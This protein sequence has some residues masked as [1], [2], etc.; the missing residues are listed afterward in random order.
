MSVINYF[1]ENIILPLSDSITRQNVSKHLKFLLNSQWFDQNEL[2]KYQSEKLQHLL[3]HSYQNVPYYH[4]LFKDLGIEPSDIKSPGDLEKLPILTKRIIR[5]NV[6]KNT[7]IAGNIPSHQKKLCSSSG[8]TGEPLF[9]YTSKNAYGKR[10][11]ASLRGWYWMGYRLGDKYVKISQN[12]RSR[13][14]KRVQDD[15]SRNRYLPSNPLTYDNYRKILENIEKYQ[16]KVIRC[17]PDP[18]YFIAKYLDSSPAYDINPLAVTTTGNTLFPEMRDVIEKGFK[19]RIFDAYSCEGSTT[20]FEC[21]THECYHSAMEFG[22][23]EVLDDNGKVIKDGIGRL[24]STDLTNLVQPFIRYDTQDYVEVSSKPCSCGR[25]LLRINRI[26]GRANDVLENRD[27]RKFIVH[28]FTGFFQQDNPQLKRSINNFQI[29]KRKG[30]GLL[31][32]LVVNSFYDDSVCDYIKHFW[33]NE[34]RENINIEIVNEIPLLP[35]GK[36]KFIIV[37]E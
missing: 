34:Y 20:I 23:T 3:S 12:P 5:E 2:L 31:F 24:V 13:L 37:E 30:G 6:N 26:L 35:T 16:P 9:Y 1:S 18:L 7:I 29:I 33:R 27:G 32:R 22:I 15:I 36:R 14:M 17:Y 19:C 10:I 28:N 25:A 11:A 8:S 4:D 21:P